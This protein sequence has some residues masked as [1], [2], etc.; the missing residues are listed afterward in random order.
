MRS[1]KFL[2][3]IFA[4]SPIIGKSQ[5]FD[6][7]I[8]F[9]GIGD[10][11]EYHSQKA[12]SQT[13]LGSRGAFEAGLKID[14]HK[15]RAGLNHLLEFGSDI[16]FHKPKLTLYY[17][18]ND[19]IKQFKFGAFPRR[20][21]INFPLAIL[22]DTLLYYRPNIEG[23]YGQIAWPWGHQAGFVDWVSRQ[24]AI[25]RENFMAGLSGEVFHKYLFM[26]N[27]MLLFHDAKATIHIPGDHIKDYFGYLITGG[28]RTF[29]NDRFTG[30][31]KA[32]VLGSL[33]R[34]RSVTNGFIYQNSFYAEVKGK[35]KNYGIN[36]TLHTGGSHRFAYGDKFY[37]TKNYW[38]TDL[39]WYFINHPKV[40][41][42]FNLSFHLIEW[43]C[44]DQQQQM[45][46]IYIF[47]KKQ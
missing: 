23:L 20:N 21:T 47:E 31:M 45:S 3:I 46:I 44:L 32:G 1:L 18:Y 42:T 39:I 2:L 43:N 41:G 40:K 16:D 6:Y 10:N 38:R 9:E 24:T 5:I 7:L 37:G 22:T 34:E 11:R 33:F 19:K 15:I 17:Q 8:N 29:N 13:I 28:I 36:S 27:Y 14:N 25:N 4:L 30:Y 12:L 26:E 35:L